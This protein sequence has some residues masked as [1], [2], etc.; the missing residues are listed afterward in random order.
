MSELV[1]RDRH[2]LNKTIF[3]PGEEITGEFLGET[4][5]IEQGVVAW[6]KKGGRD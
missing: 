3:L 5:S 6:L 4:K 1:Y 2:E